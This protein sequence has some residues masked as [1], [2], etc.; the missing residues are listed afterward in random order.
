MCHFSF[1]KGDFTSSDVKFDIMNSL[2]NCTHDNASNEHTD[3]TIMQADVVMSDMAMNFC[4]D[5][6]TD[7][8]RTISLCED[9]LDFAANPNRTNEESLSPEDCLLREDGTFLCKFFSCGQKHEQ[10]LMTAAKYYFSKVRVIKPLASR[11][12]SSEKYLLAMKFKGLV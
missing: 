6:L 1:H 12:D 7:A 11:K 9:A 8:L 4:G 5:Q 3:R 10:D 2:N